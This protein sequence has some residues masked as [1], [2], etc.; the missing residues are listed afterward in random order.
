MRTAL[1]ELIEWCNSQ[2]VDAS[3]GY[4]ISKVKKKAT[5]LLEQE[6]RQI[7]NAYNCGWNNANILPMPTYGYE[8]FEDTFTNQ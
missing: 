2:K 1:Q 3:I 6:R 4:G 7:E 8:Y 5:E